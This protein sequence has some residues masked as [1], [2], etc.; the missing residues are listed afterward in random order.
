[1]LQEVFDV[2]AEVITHPVLNVPV[3]LPFRITEQNKKQEV[4]N[5][6]K[7]GLQSVLFSVLVGARCCAQMRQSGD[8]YTA[9]LYGF[10]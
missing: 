7:K 1:M 4:R 3:C 10:R 5:T 6:M 9:A 8:I 2:E